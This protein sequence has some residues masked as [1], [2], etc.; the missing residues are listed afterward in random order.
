[1]QSLLSEH[2]HSVRFLRP[3]L[4]DGVQTMHR[5]LR[6]RAWVLLLDPVTQKFHRVPPSVWQLLQLLDG[7]RTLEDVWSAACA[8][9]GSTSTDAD[10]QAVA[11]RGQT[12]ARPL[13]AAVSQQE[14][15]QLVASLHSNDLLQT[16]VSPD[17]EEVFER[18]RRQA[19]Q[20]FKQSWLNPI[21]IRIP[22]FHP[23]A[24]FTRQAGLARILVS[25][26]T[27]LL[28]FA[29]VLPAGVLGW[30]HWTPLTANLSD[31]VLSG[32]NV[33]LLWFTYPLVKTVHEWAHGI[34]VKAYGGTV[35]E[36]GLMMI[37]FM[38]VPYVD[39]TS[40]YRFPS[41][42]ARALV[43]ATGIMAELAMGAIALYVWLMAESGLVTAVAFNVV[44]IAG[45]STVLV[46][47][48]PLMR[49]DGYFVLCDLLEIPN[50]GQRATQY[51]VYLVDRYG[52]GARDA[53]PPLQVEGERLILGIYGALGPPYRLF[54]TF[55]LIWF[56]AAEYLFVGAVMAVLALWAAVLVPIW[57]GWKHLHS[58]NSLARRRDSAWRRT[59]AAIVLGACFFGLLPLPFYSVQQAVVWVPDEAMVRAAESGHVRVGDLPNGATVKPGQVLMQLDNPPLLAEL[60]VAAAAVAEA[61]A[62]LRQAEFNASSRVDVLR[63]ELNARLSKLADVQAR[64]DGL[65]VV[66]AMAGKWVP[67]SD[68]DWAGR[69]VRR[70]DLIGHVVSGPSQ[71]LR[72][73]VTQDDM[74]LIQSRLRSVEVRLAHALHDPV[75]AKVLRPVPGGERSL[76]SAALGTAGGGSI[77]VDPSDQAG[78]TTLSRVFDIELQMAQ[79]SS[80]AVFGERAHVRFDLG[81]APLAWQW[82]MRLRQLFL[83]RLSV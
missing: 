64:I 6:G 72:T 24:W 71:V 76:V 60:G 63:G 27:L 4:R 54:I 56:V 31:R 21:S 49:Y 17:A 23:D 2:W 58:G 5:Q 34:A 8:V 14:L 36:I 26:P 9:P 59:V 44:L 45:V 22:L 15:V 28:W 75:E 73:A 81:P 7:R 29:L 12:Q 33:L 61:Q 40:S 52:F 39:A 82:Y 83:E 3:R 32:T 53:H 38:P 10:L 1:M 78:K 37:V 25:W 13:L 77:P 67:Q 41:K 30:Q 48:N 51:W 79:P 74:N 11:V 69:H 80:V 68:T 46:N 57:K 50:L 70:G 19:R 18:H 43:A 42:W 62:Q 65:N 55:G 20:R 16:Q 47:G 66:A 35:R